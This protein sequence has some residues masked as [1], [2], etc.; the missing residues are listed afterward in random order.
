M[1]LLVIQYAVQ[2]YSETYKVYY[3]V[4]GFDDPGQNINDRQNTLLY[5]LNACRDQGLKLY[6]GLHLAEDMWFSA[7]EAGFRDVG[8]PF[9]RRALNFPAGCSTIC[10]NSSDRNMTML[11]RAGT[12]PMSLTICWGTADGIVWWRTFTSLL[13]TILKR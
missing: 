1:E 5:A 4:P 7:M 3:Y 8:A 11:L 6:L 13:L 2:Y 12:C 10:G 9:L